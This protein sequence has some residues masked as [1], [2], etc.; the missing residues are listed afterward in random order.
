MSFETMSFETMSFETMSFETMS[1][2]TMSFETMSRSLSATSTIF[3]YN[4]GWGPIGSRPYM[5]T[6]SLTRRNSSEIALRTVS[7]RMVQRSPDSRSFW[8]R[9]P[10]GPATATKTVP[11]SCPSR[12]VDARIGHGVTRRRRRMAWTT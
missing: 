11:T 3:S 12:P 8:T 7:L 6:G 2:E 4:A 9:V 5:S 10:S 1:F